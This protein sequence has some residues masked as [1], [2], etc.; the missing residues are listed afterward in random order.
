MTA[1]EEVTQSEDLSGGSPQQGP[2]DA[3]DAR[4]LLALLRRVDDLFVRSDP[5]LCPTGVASYSDEE[6]DLLRVDVRR[7]LPKPST[8]PARSRL[9]I[10]SCSARKDPNPERIPAI[11]RYDGPLWQTLRTVDPD[12]KQARVAFLSAHYGFRVATTPIDRYDAIMTPER[13]KEMVEGGTYTRWPRPKS[14]KLQGGGEHAEMHMN[15]VTRD[16]LY[17]I[18]EVALV[19]GGLYL[20]VMHAFIEE[21]RTKHYLTEDVLVTEI[22]GPIGLMRRELRDWLLQTGQSSSARGE[23]PERREG[24]R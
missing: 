1:I 7:A 3:I 24:P 14:W 2:I 16:G 11:E 22:N 9:L 18:S 17:P 6:W 10:L 21:F 13:A 23:A 4:R 15:A 8:Q 5:A 20:E 19:G 12:G